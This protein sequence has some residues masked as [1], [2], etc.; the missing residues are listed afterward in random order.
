MRGF[1]WDNEDEEEVTA[2]APGVLVR[3]RPAFEFPI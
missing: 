3:N 1:E 2:V